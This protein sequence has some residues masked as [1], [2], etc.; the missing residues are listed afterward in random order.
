MRFVLEIFGESLDFKLF[1]KFA[2][3]SFLIFRHCHAHLKQKNNSVRTRDGHLEGCEPQSDLK[4]N[5][6][7]VK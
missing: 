4:I 7:E 1:H 3:A 5:E 2:D 6:I